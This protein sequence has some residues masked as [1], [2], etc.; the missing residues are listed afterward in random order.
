MNEY[1]VHLSFRNPTFIISDIV[2]TC[3]TYSVHV[4]FDKD[5]L[6][7]GKQPPSA[8][9]ILKFHSDE[10]AILIA[11]HC[12]SIRTISKYLY[13]ADDFPSIVE[14][15]KGFEHHI[16]DG[17]FAV[18]VETHNKRIKQEQ[19]LPL[20]NQLIPALRLTSKVDLKNPNTRIMLFIQYSEKEE[21]T[22]PQKF[23]L[24]IK[25]ADGIPD[26]P[27]QFTLKKRKF[28]NKTSMEATVALHSAVQ[29]LAQPGKIIY[30]PFCGSGS[31]LVACASLGANVF[32]SDLDFKSMTEQGYREEKTTSIL[33]N[34]EQYKLTHKFIGLIQLDFLENKIRNPQLD[35]I[36]TDPPYGIREKAVAIGETQVSPLYPL[37]LRLYEFAA[38][39]LRIGGRLVYWLPCGY[40]LDEENDLPKHPSL[41]LISNCQQ[42]LTSRYCRHLLTYEKTCESDEKVQFSNF[43]A[44]WLKVYELVYA[45]N[46]IK[47]RKLRKKHLKAMKKEASQKAKE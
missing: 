24:G 5:S 17:T 31:L 19:S 45:P 11:S 12:I 29:G 38:K 16:N 22:E 8:F 32:G 26:F 15:C 36:V 46:E 37:L 41:K 23:F 3:Q 4:E 30:D 44:S 21:E 14:F 43:E 6:K 40:D 9:I 33:S 25:L 7:L 2:A 20:I 39:N 10:D 1:I 42:Y 28:I 35:A 13:S 18:R 47:D 27:D 34:F